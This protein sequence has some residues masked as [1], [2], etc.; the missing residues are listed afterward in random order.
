MRC[1]LVLTFLMTAAAATEPRQDYVDG[2]WGQIHVRVDGPAASGAPTVFLIHQVVWSSAQFKNA[3][4]QLA[5]LGVRSIAVDL[6]GYGLS[7][8]PDHVPDADAYRGSLDRLR[9][10]LKQPPDTLDLSG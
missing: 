2:P 3:Q 5:A 8:G 7:D 9:D 1:L 6:P 10:D 4:P